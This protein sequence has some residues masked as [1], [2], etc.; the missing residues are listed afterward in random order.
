[1]VRLGVKTH[2]APRQIEGSVQYVDEAETDWQLWNFGQLARDGF[3]ASEAD[4]KRA[5]EFFDGALEIIEKS[6][7]KACSKWNVFCRMRSDTRK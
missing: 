3:D 6:K 7:Q 4:K 1:M 5:L 2:L